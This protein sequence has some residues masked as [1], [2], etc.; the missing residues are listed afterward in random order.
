MINFKEFKA[1][2]ASFCS[3]LLIIAISPAVFSLL[4]LPEGE[5]F[6]ELWLLEE[7]HMAENFPFIV[8]EGE[9]HHVSVS[10]SNHMRSSVYYTLY[11]WLLNRTSAISGSNHHDDA[12]E[13][14]L[15]EYRIILVHDETWERY[16]EF[17]LSN[18]TVNEGSM[19]V[20]GISINGSILPV[21]CSTDWDSEDQ[22]F[23]YQLLMNLWVL[24]TTSTEFV[25][26]NRSVWIWL[27][28]TG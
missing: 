14:P 15:Y 26:H 23:Y 10:I 1:L 28:I 4:S 27:N 5:C 13:N 25:S 19:H 2:Y 22:G 11:V 7:G 18:V 12:F 21:S 8:R 9:T 24:N 3:V 20:G 17:S 16:I 6:T